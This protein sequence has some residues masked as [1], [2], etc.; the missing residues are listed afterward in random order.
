MKYKLKTNIEYCEDCSMYGE[1][2]YIEHCLEDSNGNCEYVYE[3]SEEAETKLFETFETNFGKQWD[4]ASEDE[5]VVELKPG[6]DKDII[7]AKIKTVLKEF[8]A[9]TLQGTLTT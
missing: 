4:S 5:M 9:N 2:I 3:V 7:I 6:D 1:C 8:E